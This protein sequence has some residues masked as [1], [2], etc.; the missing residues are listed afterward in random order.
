MATEACDKR[1]YLLRVEIEK[2]SLPLPSFEPS[3]SSVGYGYDPYDDSY[4]PKHDDTLLAVWNGDLEGEES[5]VYV[6]YG[7]NLDGG[8]V[9]RLVNEYLQTGFPILEWTVRGLA[10]EICQRI[11]WEHDTW[12]EKNP[13]CLTFLA[14]SK[15]YPHVESIRVA[16]GRDRDNKTNR[17]EEELQ[18]QGISAANISSIKSDW[19]D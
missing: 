4:Y 9:V 10:P 17:L 15:E 5:H 2:L 13:H 6:V 14:G 8:E 16:S 19:S 3:Q 1:Q 11:L 12:V 7:G 18:R